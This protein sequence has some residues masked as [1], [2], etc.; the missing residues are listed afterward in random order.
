[1]LRAEP[2]RR[3]SVRF[4]SDGIALAG[5][6]YRPPKVPARARTPAIVMCG[7][8]SS[9]KEMTVPHYAERFA[10]AG[11]SVLTFDPRSLGESGTA[12]GRP[13]WHY[14]PVEVVRDYANATNYLFARDDIDPERVAAVGVCMGGGYA[15]SLAARE[16]RLRAAACIA[17]GSD[18]GDYFQ[19]WFGTEAFA[20]YLRRI[21]ELVQKERA[22]GEPQYV[23]TIARALDA[24]T[25]V[26]VMPFAAAFHY[27]DTTAREEAPNWSYKMTAGS[28]LA[29]FSY[30]AVPHAAMAA[31]TPLLFV[32]GTKDVELPPEYMLS[33]YNAAAGRKQ[34]VWIEND[35]H[36]QF[37]N[38]TPWVPSAAASVLDW[39]RERM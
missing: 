16:H 9:V 11:Y 35:N 15:I 18:S 24:S 7:P 10:D 2:A 8:I 39:L 26:A 20:D 12:P 34:F 28:I 13:R 5:H 33:V 30:S 14:D 23:P 22:T 4:D 19:K 31:P 36:F 32:S 21:N 1:L 37:Y 27:Y 38:Q 6:L 25:P 29:W 17:G 3:V